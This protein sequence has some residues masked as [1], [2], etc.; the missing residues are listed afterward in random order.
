MYQS[1]YK[2]GSLFLQ[3]SNDQW[4]GVAAYVQW[5]ED[6]VMSNKRSLEGLEG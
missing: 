3:G 4:E 2:A 1:V 6:K 5:R